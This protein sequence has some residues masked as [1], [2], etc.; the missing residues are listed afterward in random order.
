MND[1]LPQWLSKIGSKIAQRQPVTPEEVA[2]LFAHAADLRSAL[3]KAGFNFA[4]FST[5]TTVLLDRPDPPK[6]H[7]ITKESGHGSLPGRG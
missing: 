6:V 3:R 2:M 1:S 7:I 4:A 5:Q